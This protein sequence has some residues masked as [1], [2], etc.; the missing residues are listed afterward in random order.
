MF[1]AGRMEE[2]SSSEWGL[3]NVQVSLA[4]KK[5]LPLLVRHL[6]ITLILWPPFIGTKIKESI[7]WFFFIIIIIIGMLNIVTTS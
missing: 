3:V 4:L 2:A 5:W 6:L 1:P 7:H